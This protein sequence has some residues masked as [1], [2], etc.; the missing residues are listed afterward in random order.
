MAQAASP[1][2][3]MA[4]PW[5]PIPAARLTANARPRALNE[6]VT[7]SPSSLIYVLVQPMASPSRRA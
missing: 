5:R 7:L 1:A 3:G 6:A 2:L 4:I